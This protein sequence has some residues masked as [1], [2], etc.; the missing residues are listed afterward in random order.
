MA[1]SREVELYLRIHQYRLQDKAQYLLY[2]RFV[3]ILEHHVIVGM[4]ICDSVILN[5]LKITREEYQMLLDKFPR[6]RRLV[7]KVIRAFGRNSLSLMEKERAV[8]RINQ[9][10]EKKLSRLKAA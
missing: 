3:G 2:Y 5:S 9:A 7:L 4:P 8:I 1:F 10:R 6:L